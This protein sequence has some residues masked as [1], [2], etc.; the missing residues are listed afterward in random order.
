M[1]V[2]HVGC[3]PDSLYGDHQGLYRVWFPYR[4]GHYKRPGEKTETEY[5]I[6]KGVIDPG[7][8]KGL[9]NPSEFTNIARWMVA[10]GFSDAEVG[11]VMGGNALKLLRRVWG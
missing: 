1:G 9:E 7:Y 8:V 11:K 4:L 3:G 6:P 2:V 10:N 5:P